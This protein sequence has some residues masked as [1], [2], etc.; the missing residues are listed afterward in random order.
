MTNQAFRI[1]R[2]GDAGV[3]FLG[4]ELKDAWLVLGGVFCGLFAGS[5]FQMGTTGYLGFPIGGYMLNRL[6][7]EWQNNNLPGVF[8]CR[9]FSRGLAGY[10]PTIRAQKIIYVG[11]A[12]VLNPASSR[13]IDAVIVQKRVKNGN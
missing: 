11:D 9:L 10:S 13:L 8:R 2:H 4:V 1:P 5:I 7:I 12:V 6:Y 3:A